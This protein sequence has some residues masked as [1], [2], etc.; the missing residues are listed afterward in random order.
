MNEFINIL[1][2]NNNNNNKSSMLSVY[3]EDNKVIQDLPRDGIW[4]IPDELWIKPNYINKDY[5]S[6]DKGIVV[7]KKPG[8]YNISSTVSFFISNK[9]EEIVHGNALLR[10]IK[11]NIT[12][13]FEYDLESVIQTTYIP[14]TIFPQQ[15]VNEPPF[16]IKI[17]P[18]LNANVIVT[19]KDIKEKNNHFAPQ[20]NFEIFLYPDEN[21][22]KGLEISRDT[23]NVQTFINVTKL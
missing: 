18:N 12:N 10:L 11:G 19:C 20:Y 9:S 14:G 13:R 1:I 4:E 23:I 17:T 7:I 16:P 2:G 3:C 5:I 6:F 15:R 8:I 22:P 21:M